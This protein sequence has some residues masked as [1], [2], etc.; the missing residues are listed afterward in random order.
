MQY[1]QEKYSSR[2]NKGLVSMTKAGS[3]QQIPMLRGRIKDNFFP[4]FLSFITSYEFGTCFTI[5]KL[6]EWRDSE[7]H[8]N[9]KVVWEC[10]LLVQS[11]FDNPC[12]SGGLHWAWP[13]GMKKT[14]SWPLPLTFPLS[15]QETSP[16]H[17][18]MT[19][20]DPEELVVDCVLW[21]TR[22]EPGWYCGG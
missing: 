4:F 6:A 13:W 21:E 5:S 22:G 9:N 14:R 7:S 17:H 11:H 12:L 10:D 3:W 16:Q 19:T 1:V 18:G 20:T 8:W 15:N 2:Y